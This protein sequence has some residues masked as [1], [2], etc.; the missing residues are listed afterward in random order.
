MNRDPPRNLLQPKRR[1]YKDARSPPKENETAG[2]G[3]ENDDDELFEDA[4]SDSDDSIELEHQIRI[5]PNYGAVQ[6]PVGE[7]GGTDFEGD[8]AQALLLEEGEHWRR[9]GRE[10]NNDKS[11]CSCGCI[12]ALLLCYLVLGGGGVGGLYRAHQ[13]GYV[14]HPLLTKMFGNKPEDAPSSKADASEEQEEG[15]DHLDENPD[16]LTDKEDTILENGDNQ[17]K[18]KKEEAYESDAGEHKEEKYTGT[19]DRFL[20]LKNSDQQITSEFPHG[21]VEQDD[22]IRLPPPCSL[23][24]PKTSSVRMDETGHKGNLVVKRDDEELDLHIKISLEL[25]K[26]DQV[27]CASVEHDSGRKIPEFSYVHGQNWEFVC[28]VTKASTDDAGKVEERIDS[29]GKVETV[30]VDCTPV[31]SPEDNKS[32]K[33]DVADPLNKDNH[34]KSAEDKVDNSDNPLDKSGK[35]VDTNGKPEDKKDNP[36]DKS[37]KP[38]DKKDKSKDKN[39][40]PLDK[41][42]KPEDKNNKP[43]EDK[44]AKTDPLTQP[45]L[46]FPVGTTKTDEH[47][48]LP[49]GCAALRL[50]PTS[51]LKLDAPNEANEMIHGVVEVGVEG[52]LKPFPITVTVKPLEKPG[53]NEC[54]S[55]KHGKNNEVTITKYSSV[56]ESGV[57]CVATDPPDPDSV[58]FVKRVELNGDIFDT[59]NDCTRKKTELSPEPPKP[60]TPDPTP[61][62]NKPLPEWPKDTEMEHKNKEGVSG[63]LL[64]DP[65]KLLLPHNSKFVFNEGRTGGEV[66][67]KDVTLPLKVALTPDASKPDEGEVNCVEVTRTNGKK[68]S[69][70]PPDSYVKTDGSICLANAD[71]TITQLITPKGEN[72]EVSEQCEPLESVRGFPLRTRFDVNSEKEC[73]GDV[74][75]PEPN[76]SKYSDAHARTYRVAEETS[77]HQRL[78]DGR[79]ID[80]T[81]VDDKPN[82]LIEPKMKPKDLIVAS[83]VNERYAALGSLQSGDFLEDLYIDLANRVQVLLPCLKLPG[84]GTIAGVPV[85]SED[86][87]VQEKDLV[88]TV[89]FGTED[90]GYQ[91]DTGGENPKGLIKNSV[92]VS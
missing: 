26:N 2:N 85:D 48:V 40:N 35:P 33:K 51:R 17:D 3:G 5:H 90:T 6:H 21:S 89:F 30:S 8:N 14:K 9:R 53:L 77:F 59:E 22:F 69:K 58:V 29:T 79:P 86:L 23:K 4:A 25:G 65:C 63:I 28:V 83:P 82:D 70:I 88:P 37:G 24:L 49:E 76:L 38:E 47:I 42:G 20:Q 19:G 91:L 57:L 15:A 84:G 80:V 16:E 56:Q 50:P 27:D 54:V 73:Y 55:V 13:L 41:S 43:P 10:N 46:N 45:P 66:R 18:E 39:D 12:L 78:L 32:P 7:T 62:A 11:C 44:T 36:L 74:E 67:V 81:E 71:G 64:P 87:H 92:Q 31:E 60:P 52:S 1:L 61:P 72:K 34:P 68:S 75:Y